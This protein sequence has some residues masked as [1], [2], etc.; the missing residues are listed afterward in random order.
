MMLLSKGKGKVV[1][2]GS[3]MGGNIEDDGKRDKGN[4]DVERSGF[5]GGS[6]LEIQK[7]LEKKG[8]SK[9]FIHA[10]NMAEMVRF[11]QIANRGSEDSLHKVAV[12]LNSPNKLGDAAVLGSESFSRQISVGRGEVEVG[13]VYIKGRWMRWACEAGVRNNVNAGKEKVTDVGFRSGWRFHYEQCWAGKAG[14]F[15]LISDDWHLGESGDNLVKVVNKLAVCSKKLSYWNFSNKRDMHEDIRVKNRELAFLE[16]GS[17]NQN[18]E[19]RNRVELELD[20]F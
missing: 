16:E 8:D 10:G 17:R 1:D 11:E 20:G 14:C 9:E 7:G 18:W 13:V 15:D 19:R 4:S 3:V 12:F 5:C 6:F 2:E